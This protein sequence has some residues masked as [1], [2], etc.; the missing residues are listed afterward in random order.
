MSLLLGLDVP[1]DAEDVLRVIALLD[2]K[3]SIVII[4]IGRPDAVIGLV[5][6]LEIDVVPTG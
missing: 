4:A 3:Q 2:F 1:I 6:S 5:G